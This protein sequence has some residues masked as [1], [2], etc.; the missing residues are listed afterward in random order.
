MSPEEAKR[1]LD[2]LSED[3]GDVNRKPALPPLGRKPRKAW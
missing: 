3:P 2:A 1:L